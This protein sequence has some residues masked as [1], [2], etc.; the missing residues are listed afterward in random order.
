MKK[1]CVIVCIFL[2]SYLFSM[3]QLPKVLLQEQYS[4]L[5][6]AYNTTLLRYINEQINYN[7]RFYSREEINQIFT[8]AVENIALKKQI[9]FDAY[10]TFP[11]KQ[12]NS[13]SDPRKVMN[14]KKTYKS[15]TWSTI[16]GFAAGLGLGYLLFNEVYVHIITK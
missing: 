9:T 10:A 11:L 8:T 14:H 15:C 1:M 16:I 6:S 3:E 2:V 12:N 4:A 5:L 13:R 7:S